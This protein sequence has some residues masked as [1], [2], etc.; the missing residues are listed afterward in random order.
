MPTLYTTVYLSTKTVSRDGLG[1]EYTTILL[2]TPPSPDGHYYTTVISATRTEYVEAGPWVLGDKP[3]LAVGIVFI[4]VACAVFLTT[5]FMLVGLVRV[6]RGRWWSS[7]EVAL[8]QAHAHTAPMLQA[9]HV[10]RTML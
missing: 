7:T 4:V 9:S 5:A 10:N 3:L 8:E 1:W 2:P 6:R